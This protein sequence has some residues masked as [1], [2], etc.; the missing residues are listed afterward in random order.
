MPILYD[1]VESKD[2]RSRTGEP[3]QLRL[4]HNVPGNT[5]GIDTTNTMNPYFGYSEK[6]ARKTFKHMSKHYEEAQL[7]GEMERGEI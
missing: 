1:I 5:W 6:G 2:F 3:F 4:L 7:K